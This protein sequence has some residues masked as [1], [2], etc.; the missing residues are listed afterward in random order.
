M[1]GEP[2]LHLDETD[3]TNRVAL[4]WQDAPHG[5][6]VVARSQTSGRGRLG[7]NWESAADKGLYFSLILRVENAGAPLYSLWS[8]LGVAV[9]LEKLSGAVF[10]LKW[11]NDVL[12]VTKNGEAR[13]IGGILCEGRGEKLVV[14]IGVNVNH[15]EDELPERPIFPA[16]SLRL[17]TGRVFEIDAVLSAILDELEAVFAQ[18]WEESHAEFRRRCFGLGDVVRVKSATESLVG[19]FEGVGED[20]ALLLRTADGAKRIVAGD[21]SYF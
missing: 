11:P 13:K 19:V 8:A 15:G 9:A 10:R 21:V 5:A 14:G 1:L 3:S 18:S 17:E 2:L 20:G 16:S 12:C 6:C 7:R 4:D